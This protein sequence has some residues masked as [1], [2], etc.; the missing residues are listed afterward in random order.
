MEINIYLFQNADIDIIYIKTAR[1][2]MP[3]APSFSLRAL[4]ICRSMDDDAINL[5]REFGHEILRAFTFLKFYV[6]KDFA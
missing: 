4:S 5:H 2:A 6:A 3:S 1:L